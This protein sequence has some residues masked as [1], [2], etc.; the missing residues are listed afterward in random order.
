M[1]KELVDQGDGL[2]KR[3]LD[4]RPQEAFFESIRDKCQKSMKF[5][6]F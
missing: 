5:S 2:P 3:H 1:N 4:T 6:C